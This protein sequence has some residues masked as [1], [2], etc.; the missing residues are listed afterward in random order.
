MG[1]ERIWSMSSLLAVLGLSLSKRVRPPQNK[2]LGG[3]LPSDS[4]DYNSY[5]TSF[6]SSG[7]H[8]AGKTY[9]GKRLSRT[10]ARVVGN[11]S[12]NQVNSMSSFSMSKVVPEHMKKSVHA[13]L[14]CPA[15][16]NA[17]TLHS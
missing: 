15:R 4:T 7:S 1:K 8:D 5:T 10:G 9:S 11:V 12:E 14:T 3:A 2:I 16:I 13:P 17:D 6:I